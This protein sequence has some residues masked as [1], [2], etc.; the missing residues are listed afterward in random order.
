M[1]DAHRPPRIALADGLEIS[2]VVTGLWQVADQE[3]D[4]GLLDREAAA[5]AM[6]DYAEAG[7]DAFDM[8]DHYGSA[9]EIAGS[10]LKRHAGPGAACF[11]K[12]CPEPGPMTREVVRAGVGRSMERLGVET[13]DLM[14]FHWWSFAH[15]GYLDAMREMAV[16][17]EE[18]LV[19]ALG[20]TNFDTDHLRVLVGMGVPVATNQVSFSLVDRRAREDLSAFCR[21]SGTRL[22]AY[23]TLCGGFLTDR[24]VGRPEP[25]AAEIPDWSK[26]KYKRF[27]DAIGGWSALQTILSA[28]KAIADKHGV[29][30]ANVATRWVLEQEMVAAIIVGAR[31]TER[32]HRADTMRLFGFSL[33]AEDHA[34]LEDAFAR[35]GRVPGDCGDEYRK[36]PFLTASGDLSHHLDAL[37]PVYQ[38]SPVP[39]RPDRLRIDTGS[40][41]EDIAGY[42]RAMRIGER[43]LV[44]G[45]TATHGAGEVVCPGDPA[46]QAVYILD[47]IRASVEALG[48]RMEDVVRTRV[49][50]ADVSEWEPVSRVHGRVFADVRPANTLLAV[51]A[52]VGDYRVEIEAEAIVG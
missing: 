2:R 46:G 48:G 35:T 30:V 26:S 8:A 6:A 25:T 31:L 50:L 47:K 23:G 29:S 16:M 19:R 13:V 21:E 15:P 45:T 49:Y 7:F 12:W 24:W 37:P 43:I 4:G 14:Q 34:R 11:T 27:I 3:R 51:G 28:A 18:G 36:P 1:S 32:E 41:W 5:R 52:L 17:K 33:D 42:A 22:L 9:E 38:P 39:G 10:F 40:V 44:S 20:V